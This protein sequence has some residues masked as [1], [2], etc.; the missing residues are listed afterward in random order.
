MF[1]IKTSSN[2]PK[3]VVQAM[4]SRVAVGSN[5]GCDVGFTVGVAVG[6]CVGVDVGATVGVAVGCSVGV[7]VAVA[8]QIN[9][10]HPTRN[11]V[12]EHFI[13]CTSIGSLLHAQGNMEI[14]LEAGK[15]SNLKTGASKVEVRW[16][17]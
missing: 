14:L 5:V 1:S 3:R 16:A 8:P 9:Q 2:P 6:S 11:A 12:L 13:I 10:H 17:C 7:S 15:K 4:H